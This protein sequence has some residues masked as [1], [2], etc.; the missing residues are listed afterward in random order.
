MNQTALKYITLLFI[1]ETMCSS[2]I[3]GIIHALFYLPDRQHET[4]NR[5]QICEHD[6]ILDNVMESC[7][8]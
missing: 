6:E 5:G 1:N 8:Y 2:M 7:I 4:G 3:N